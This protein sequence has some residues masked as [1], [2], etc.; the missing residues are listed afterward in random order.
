[1]P[2]FLRQLLA[3]PTA[4]S[5]YANGIDQLHAFIIITTMLASTFVGVVAVIF[6][7]KNHRRSEHQ[8]T[9]HVQVTA[10]RET[11]LI[12]GILSLFLLWWVIG[13]VQFI[14]MEEAPDDARVV[15]VTGKQWMWKFAY[16]E[17]GISNDI[18]TVEE[19]R[20]V[21]LVMTSRDVI[22]SFYVPNFRMKQDVIPGRYVTMWFKPTVAGTYPIYCAEYCGVEHSMMLGEVRVLPPVEYERWLRDT[23]ESLSRRSLASIGREVAQ[24]RGCSGCHSLDGQRHVGPSFSRLYGAT[25]EL[26]GGGHVVA[27]EAYLTRSMMDPQKDIVAGYKSV[28]PTYLG[29]LPE[30]EVA[31]LVE[32]IKSLK[33]GPPPGE[34]T[35]VA[36][37]RLEV[38][39]LGDAGADA[40]SEEPK[41]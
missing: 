3:V 35:G 5:S 18:L 21:K 17:G 12:G 8:L 27:D 9:P 39:A 25:V 11:L 24:K 37:P 33:D 14:Q 1:M 36:L 16:A 26:T 6:V 28:M 41:K 30:P 10:L 19:G 34:S 20:P 7:I 40:A 15:Y 22:H 29:T 2:E 31:A 38:T 13:Y 32:L 23:T 4:A